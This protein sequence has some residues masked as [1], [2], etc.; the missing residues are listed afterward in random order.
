[1]DDEAVIRTRAL[2]DAASDLFDDDA[3]S[4][5]VRIGG[6]SAEHARVG[7]GHRV[8]DV[9]CGSGG[10]AVPAA[11]VVGPD[12]HVPGV[13]LSEGLLARA[14]AQASSAGLDAPGRPGRPAVDAAGRRDP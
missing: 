7:P 6:R 4:F 1:M 10:S 11:E 5:F 9:A 14:R 12:G 3:L 8:L 13:D 2:F